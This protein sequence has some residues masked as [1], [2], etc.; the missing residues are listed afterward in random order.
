MEPYQPNTPDEQPENPWGRAES[1]P[2]GTPSEPKQ[3]NNPYDRQFA[4]TEGFSTA[5]Q[6]PPSQW[7]TVQ[8]GSQPPPRPPKKNRGL[9]AF[10]VVMTVLF[11]GTLGLFA[12]TLLHRGEVGTT[13]ENVHDTVSLVIRDSEDDDTQEV[14]PDGS[15]SYRQI[16]AKVCPSVVG[17]VAHYNTQS[18]TMTSD[19]EGS[20]VILTADGYIVTNAHVVSNVSTGEKAS[21]VEVVM[22]AD[23]AT[24][25][26]DVVGVDAKT[27][28]AVLKITAPDLSPA[29]LGDS[30]ACAVGDIVLAVGNPGGLSLA[31]SVTQGIISAVDRPVRTASTG[32]TMNCIQTDAAINPGNSGGALVN[33]HG[34]VIGIN[35]SKLVATSYEGIGFAIAMADVKPIVEDLIQNGY[36]PNRARLGITYTMITEETAQANGAVAGL[37]VRSIADD[38][39][40]KNSEL[41]EGDI[42]THIDGEAMTSS[43]RVTELLR[44]KAPGD[45]VQLTVSRTQW[46]SGE[47]TTFTV[48]T[49]LVA[50]TGNSTVSSPN[51]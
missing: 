4:R 46:G 44:K 22:P 35:S 40:L 48:T 3:T 49:T 27:D 28:L 50:D 34:Q 36:V 23:S 37:W 10:A 15:L 51:E 24:Y 1:T 30:T 26:A 19:G 6:V 20:G 41:R 32:Y 9:A 7:R 8:T 31:G 17:V 38:S 39:N 25:E 12:A 21:R 5:G 18:Q 14:S 43:N 29:E 13:D 33:D 47:P 16:A 2:Y 45:T 11:L 42:I